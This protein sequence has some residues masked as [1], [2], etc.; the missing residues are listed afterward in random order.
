MTVVEQ[1]IAKLKGDFKQSFRKCNENKENTVVRRSP[2]L[3]KTRSPAFSPINT[4]LRMSTLKK[5]FQKKVLFQ[6]NTPKSEKVK[7]AEV[8][9]NSLRQ[10]H[11]LLRT[12]KFKSNKEE[13]IQG[14][15]LSMVLQQQCLMLQDT[16]AHK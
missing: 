7:K 8:M 12:P 2:R 13:V 9:Y 4:N 1:K 3:Q 11:P 16:P 15:S 5:N 14:Q 6:D 10:N